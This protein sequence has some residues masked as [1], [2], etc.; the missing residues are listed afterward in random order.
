ME[1]MIDQRRPPS[2]AS[3]ETILRCPLRCKHCGLS[4][5]VAQPD[6]LTNKQAKLMLNSLSR[7]GIENLV[8]SGGE[9]TFR[10]DWQIILDCALKLF[11]SVRL[12]TCGWLKDSLF[13]QLKNI[14]HLEKLTVSVSLDGLEDQHDLRRG[15]GSFQAVMDTLSCQTNIPRTVLTTVDNKNIYD[16]SN[17]LELCLRLNVS[18]WGIQICL[19]AGRMDP[20]LFL[21]QEKIQLLAEQIKRWQNICEDSLIIEPD[22]CFANLFPERSLG[23]WTGC[24]AGRNLVTILNNGLVTGCP[25]MS[26]RICGDIRQEDISEIWNSLQMASLA[27]EI[28][29]ECLACGQCFG[30]CKAVSKLCNQQFCSHT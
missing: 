26:D 23:S 25:T 13:E 30:G 12:I 1:K 10:V 6:E 7:F 21:G 15:A 14:E 18:V 27:Q 11:R 17:I 28:P 9:F 19:P 16:L 24:P 20:N 3:W 2:H 4:A 8:I 29:G 22:D 5:G